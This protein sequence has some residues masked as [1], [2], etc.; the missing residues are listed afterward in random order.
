MADRAVI[1]VAQGLGDFLLGSDIGLQHEV[2]PG[3]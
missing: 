3:I 2:T 1:L